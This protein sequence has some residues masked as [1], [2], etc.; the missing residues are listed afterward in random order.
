MIVQLMNQLVAWL[1]KYGVLDGLSFDLYI[2]LM[3]KRREAEGSRCDLFS[4]GILTLV[5]LFAIGGKVARYAKNTL[6]LGLLDS[7]REM[8]EKP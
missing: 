7:R 4:V 5:H 1:W 2:H 6:F 8:F 3:V